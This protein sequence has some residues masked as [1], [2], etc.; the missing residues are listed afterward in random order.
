MSGYGEAATVYSDAL[1][2]AYARRDSWSVNLELRAFI[3]G[4][5]PKNKTDILNESGEHIFVD[6]RLMEDQETLPP[7]IS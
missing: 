5:Y 7:M 3:R 6:C 1:A 2:P 4:T